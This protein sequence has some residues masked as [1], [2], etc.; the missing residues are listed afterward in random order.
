MIRLSDSNSKHFNQFIVIVRRETVGFHF[1][2]QGGKKV[3]YGGKKCVFSP[4]RNVDR[5]MQERSSM[6][7][8]FQIVGAAKA[9]DRRP[10]AER[11]SGTLLSKCLSRDRRFLEGMYGVRRSDR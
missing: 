5:H 2:R 11:M 1:S 3:I 10:F 6:G 8:E 7:N 4:E 9:N